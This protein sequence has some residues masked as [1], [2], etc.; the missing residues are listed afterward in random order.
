MATSKQVEEDS[1]ARQVSALRNNVVGKS[2][3]PPAIFLEPSPKPSL[4]NRSSIDRS[5]HR[6][7]NLPLRRASRR[8]LPC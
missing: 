1:T 7:E 2:E 4:P 8:V 5:G 6:C 3:E